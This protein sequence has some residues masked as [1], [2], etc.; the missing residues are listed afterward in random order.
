MND[1]GYQWYLVKTGLDDIKLTLH[2]VVKEGK[3]LKQIELESC[4]VLI[5]YFG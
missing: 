3:P 4:G 5:R 2:C 1:L